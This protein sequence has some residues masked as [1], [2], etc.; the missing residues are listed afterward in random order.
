MFLAWTTE[1]DSHAHTQRGEADL[2][3]RCWYSTI[4]PSVVAYIVH[5]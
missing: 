5:M 3:K 2:G 1:S 4:A